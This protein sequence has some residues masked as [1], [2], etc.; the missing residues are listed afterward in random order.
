MRLYVDTRLSLAGGNKNIFTDDAIEA[1]WR[2][3]E[4]GVPRLINKLCKLS[5]KAGETNGLAQ[6]HGEVIIQIADRFQKI[7]GNGAAKAE[8]ACHHDRRRRD[9]EPGGAAG[10]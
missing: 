10:R 1:L 2:Y 8:Q 4:Y 6:I 3:S 5:L 9:A 7:N